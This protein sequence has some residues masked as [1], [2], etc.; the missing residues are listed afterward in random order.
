[1][2]RLHFEQQGFNT[3]GKGIEYGHWKSGFKLQISGGL[4]TGWDL[5]PFAAGL[6]PGHNSPQATRYKKTLRY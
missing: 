6:A 1:M 3:P 5:G 2:Y 4:E